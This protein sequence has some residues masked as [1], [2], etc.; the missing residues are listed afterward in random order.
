MDKK[1]VGALIRQK[2]KEKE[3]TQ[4]EL[5]QTLHVSKN[6]VSKWEMG[7]NAISK[8]CLERISEVLDIPLSVLQG[9]EE[10]APQ[11]EAPLPLPDAADNSPPNPEETDSVLKGNE[12]FPDDLL[13]S[14]LQT[15]E[16]SGSNLPESES[17]D[18]Q[19]GKIKKSLFFG[20]GIIL[21]AVVATAFFIWQGNPY[22]Y[23]IQAEYFDTFEGQEACYLI[24]EYKGELTV[25]ILDEYVN[26]IREKYNEYFN[27]VNVVVVLF[28]QDYSEDQVLSL[29]TADAVAVLE[30]LPY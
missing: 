7:K 5:A 22:S 20:T 21:L 23:T 29:D 17:Q 19:L 12:A 15:K 11:A 2:R 6:A 4:E 24:T 25:E 9:N 14:D 30:P 16:L 18:K 13:E 27:E 28:C 8:P 1:S 26:A 3:M 10:D